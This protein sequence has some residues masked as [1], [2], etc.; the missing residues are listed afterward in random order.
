M[1]W[2]KC[3]LLFLRLMSVEQD[4]AVDSA[5]QLSSELWTLDLP[6]QTQLLGVDFLLFS[7]ENIKNK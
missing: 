1:I 4:T 2:E 6:V 7:K 3:Y 5:I